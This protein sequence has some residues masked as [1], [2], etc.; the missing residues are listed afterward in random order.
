VNAE[1]AARGLTFQ[2]H[3]WLADEWFT[4]DGVPGVAI[5]FYLAHPR[6]AK[7][8]LAQMLE[9][10]GGDADACM[11]ILRHEAGHAIDNAFE[12]RLRADRQKLFGSS[13]L[14]YPEYYSPKPYSR[15]FVLHLD[16]WY[17][18][19]HP[20][21]DFAETFAVWLSPRTDW[22][23]R[24][25]DWPAL[26]KLEYM[27][28][29][30]R[31]LAGREPPVTTRR[32]VDPLHRIRRTL[33]Q[34]YRRKAQ[35]YGLDYPN[36]YDQDLRRLFSDAPEHASNLPASR[37]LA[38]VRKDVRRIVADWTGVYQYTIDQ[39]LLEMM[40]RCDELGLALVTD[41]A[42]AKAD[43]LVVLTIHTM[44]YLHSGRHM[45]AL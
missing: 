29:L 42:R 6:L 27:D 31:E 5:P 32:V 23:K 26:R 28:G 39:V 11:R 40:E 21:E 30:M 12:L 7:L 45:V 41:E 9:V 16:S 13:S 25:A 19:S 4:P 1:L 22:R 43:F 33:R 3:Y 20:D 17:A 38:L 14:P 36:F 8:E 35:H 2:P 37:F 34:H 18:Q 44:N 10:E 15:S 24:Y